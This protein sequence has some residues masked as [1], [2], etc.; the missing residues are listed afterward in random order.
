MKQIIVVGHTHA[1]LHYSHV[2]TEQ[3]ESDI[4]CAT[5][6]HIQLYPECIRGC[7]HSHS[8]RA[9]VSHGRL[10]IIFIST[11]NS[12]IARH[13]GSE[14]TL[15]VAAWWLLCNVD[16]HTIIVTRVQSCVLVIYAAPRE[17]FIR[18]NIVFGKNYL[19]VYITLSIEYCIHS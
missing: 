9:N 4:R 12:N 18:Q 19:Q 11:G 14:T 6:Y 15:L 10:Q 8:N 2:F 7:V 3:R 1:L 13:C 5:H 17:L 16:T